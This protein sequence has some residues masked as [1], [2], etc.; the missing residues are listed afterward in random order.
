MRLD[1]A[2]EVF[3]RF[4]KAPLSWEANKDVDSDIRDVQTSNQV[5]VP[6]SST[7][8]ANEN[9]MDLARL[10]LVGSPFSFFVY[11]VL[12]LGLVIFLFNIDGAVATEACE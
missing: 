9:T 8:L 3:Q 5:S 7:V 6:C 2:C 1:L 10:G 11:L 12:M 4:C